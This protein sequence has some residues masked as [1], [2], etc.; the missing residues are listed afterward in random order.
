[1]AVLYLE[2][3]DWNVVRDE[4]ISGNIIQART[5]NTLKRVCSEIISR[6]KTL[7]FEELS[8]FVNTGPQEQG[9]LLWIAVC[10]R[11]RFIAEFAFEVLRERYITLKNNLGYEDF[12]SFFNKKS[13]WHAELEKIRPTTR[14]KLRQILFKIL[15][16]TDLLTVNNTINAA[17]FSP[18]FLESIPHGN[19]KDLLF[20]PV[21]EWDLKEMLM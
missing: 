18:R 4:S 12:D 15:R 11:Y 10:R 7:C 16:E 21:F 1:M 14:I 5:M 3:G 20:F 8:L 17:F 19:R 2:L 13:E 9:Y 6:L